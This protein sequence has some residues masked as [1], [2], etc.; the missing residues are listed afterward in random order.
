[1]D[2][3]NVPYLVAIVGNIPLSTTLGITCAINELKDELIEMKDVKILW[4]PFK[5][6]SKSNTQFYFMNCKLR[7]AHRRNMT[8][9]ELYRLNYLTPYFQRPSMLE[10]Q[11]PIVFCYKTIAEC[12]VSLYFNWKTDNVNDSISEAIDEHNILSESKD[13]AK[14]IDEI[15]KD[16]IQIVNEE[17]NKHQMR[18]KEYEMMDDNIRTA[19]EEVKTYKFYP[20]NRKLDVFNRFYGKAS[21]VFP[22]ISEVMDFSM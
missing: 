21:Q 14:Y 22:P 4:E 16:L 1:V 3:I 17:K 9:E 12:V 8:Q 5:W 10:E 15:K 20:Q 18:K 11:E 2:I 13:R 19:L 6:C 7:E